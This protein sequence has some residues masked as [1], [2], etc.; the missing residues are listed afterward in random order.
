MKS[1]FLNVVFVSFTLIASAQNK[2]TLK[3]A[4]ETGIKNNIDV[5]QSDLLMQ[6]ADIN[7]KQSRAD[8]LPNLNAS[9]NHGVNQGR[10]IDPF[11]NAFINQ[12]VNYASYGASS[13]ILLFNGS[14]L[15]NQIKSNELG[16]QAS[17]MELQQSKDNLTINIILTYL[18]VLSSEDILD[19]SREQKAVTDSQVTRLNILNQSGAIPPSQYYDLKGQL[20]NDEIAIVDNQAALET[21]KL[22]L[23]QLLNI[24]YN[25]YLDVEKFP[26]ESFNTFY[27]NTP[28]NIY[29]TAL[30]QFAQIK[31]THLRTQSAEKYIRSMRGQLYPT[32]SLN[33]NINTNYSSVASQEYFVN[34][35]EVTS[36]DYVLINGSQVQVIKK[37]NNYDSKK[38]T[39]GNQLNNNLFTTVNLGISIPLFNAGQ[40][41][42]KIKLAKIDLKNTQLVE[43]NSKIQL[44]QSIERA[45]VSLT[46]SSDK[47]KLLLSQVNSFAESFRAAEIRFNSGASTSVD[48]L[49]AKNNLDRAKSN[50]I[51]A[52]YDFVLRSKVLDYYQGKPLW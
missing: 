11:T 3:E 49:I 4:I 20:A 33:G 30:Q 39:Y 29:S 44:Q 43:E 7:L 40:V 51:I 27:D 15:H 16:Y 37:Q 14:S 42:N 10:S 48:Y 8:M 9:A 28:E 36:P 45:Y 31:A 52:K 2:L 38:I 41:R 21:A 6:K 18:Q 47:Y 12:K 25:K 13:N 1:F 26:E 22:N 19:R 46:S 32:I 35:T 23:A 5:L 34:S 24:P 50:L 17:K